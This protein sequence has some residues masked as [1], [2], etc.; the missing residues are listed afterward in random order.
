MD[1]ADM[2]ECVKSYLEGALSVDLQSDFGRGYLK[3][4]RS[5]QEYIAQLEKFAERKIDSETLKE[6]D[7][8]LVRNIA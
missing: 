4:L 3:S 6:I 2:F 1:K 8:A 7:E 5:L